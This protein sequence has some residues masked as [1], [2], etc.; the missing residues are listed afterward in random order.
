MWP[1]ASLLL[2]C[3]KWVA[4]RRTL[5]H[6]GVNRVAVLFTQYYTLHNMFK[7]KHLHHTTHTDTVSQNDLWKLPYILVLKYF[8][9]VR[10]HVTFRIRYEKSVKHETCI[11]GKNN[12]HKIFKFSNLKICGKTITSETS[13]LYFLNWF[14]VIKTIS[15]KLG[16]IWYYNK[17][18]KLLS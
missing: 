6:L 11:F 18:V 17:K 10:D 8:V 2:T 7:P 3:Q 16:L 15:Y 5:V 14:L 12:F 4:C 1:N 13:G 9:I